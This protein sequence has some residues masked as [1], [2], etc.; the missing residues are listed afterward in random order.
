MS[1]WHAPWWFV[2]WLGYL[3]AGCDS[4]TRPPVSPLSRPSVDAGTQG[5]VSVHSFDPGEVQAGTDALTLTLTGENFGAAP[6][7]MT[8]SA[9]G[10][11]TLLQTRVES[12]TRLTAVVPAELLRVPALAWISLWDFTPR[13]NMQLWSGYLAVRPPAPTGETSFRPTGPMN[14]P[15]GGHRAV[16]LEDGRVLIVGGE[17]R[18]AELY[19]PATERFE[20]TGTMGTTRRLPSATLLAGGKVLVAGGIGGLGRPLPLLASAELYDPVSGTFA[21]TGSMAVAR[22]EHTATLLKDGK[23][24][25]TGGNDFPAIA[26]AEVFDPQTGSFTKAGDMTTGRTEH[27]A[28]LLPS[29]QVLIAGGWNGH[30][31]DASDD[32]PWNPEWVELFDPAT[33]RFSPSAVMS[34][35][36]YGHQALQLSDGRVLLLG[37][38]P[39]VQNLHWETPHPDYAEIF[40]PVAGRFSAGPEVGTVQSR[41]TATMLLDGGVLLAGGAETSAVKSAAVLDLGQGRLSPI[42]GMSVARREHTATRL[43]DGRVLLTGGYD[44]QWNALASAELYP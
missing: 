19:D 4:Q 42:P 27:T 35:T 34:A 32:P 15:R 28:S 40:D 38:I 29:G 6:Y 2:L 8:W 33:A 44:E 31:P 7:G 22:F 21:Q 1:P 25:V 18:T 37:G 11:T 13:S 26:S 12:S 5:P 24:L 20:L 41:Y 30:L 10:R 9:T 16:L 17:E 3:G 39:Q 14:L 23:V 36:R 43:V